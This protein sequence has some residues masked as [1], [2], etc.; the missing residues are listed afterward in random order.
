M[1]VFCR[2]VILIVFLGFSCIT[3]AQI[4][5][6]VIDA[7]TEQPVPLATLSY[8]NGKWMTKADEDGRFSIERHI[9]WRLFVS[10]VG[11]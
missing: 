8:H 6:S 11:R 10:S 3:K 1:N 9:G 5:G 2:L 7:T 4:Y